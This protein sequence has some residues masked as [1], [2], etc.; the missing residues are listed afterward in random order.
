MDHCSVI[1]IDPLPEL[2]LLFV[3]ARHDNTELA[4]DVCIDDGSKENAECS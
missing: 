1:P 4:E 3:E 2:L